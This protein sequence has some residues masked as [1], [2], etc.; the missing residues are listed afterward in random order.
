M[1]GTFEEEIKMLLWLVGLICVIISLQP[2]VVQAERKPDPQSQGF[3]AVDQATIRMFSR[4]ETKAENLRD[5]VYGVADRIALEHGLPPE[6]V[7]SVIRAESNGNPAAVSPKGAMGLMQL[8]PQTAKDQRVSNPFDPVANVRGGVRYLKN[9]LGEFSGNL[10]LALAA[11]NA[12]PAAVHKH[13][14]IP[15]YPETQSFVRTVIERYQGEQEPLGESR[16]AVKSKNTGE[17]ERMPAKIYL[18]GSPRELAVLFQ[19]LQQKIWE[20]PIP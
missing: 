9:L 18:R 11:Y 16:A 13:Q 6:L 1:G 19:K 14:G 20:N 4:P 10:S 8:M 3:I 7:R 15:P 12:G 5:P 17:W 2:G